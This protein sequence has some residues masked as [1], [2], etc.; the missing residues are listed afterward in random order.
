MDHPTADQGADL[1]RRQVGAAENRKT[2]RR[3]ARRGRVDALDRGM[4]VRRAD[5]HGIGLA[6]AIDVVGILA[7]AGNEPLIFLALDGRSDAGGSHRFL[8]EA[9]GLGAAWPRP[10]PV[11]VLVRPIRPRVA[12][13]PSAAPAS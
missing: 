1:V 9:L 5:K 11:A 3:F 7:L 2:A 6:G 12:W 8:P 13:R 10:A 4:G